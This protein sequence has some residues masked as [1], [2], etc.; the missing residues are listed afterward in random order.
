MRLDAP[1]RV[2]FGIKRGSKTY[3]LLDSI[4]HFGLTL[5]CVCALQLK[6][7]GEEE[8]AAMAE[9]QALQYDHAQV[10]LSLSMLMQINGLNEL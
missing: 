9:V 5:R 3:D 8:V 2:L 10:R 7:W 1:F 6:R 4:G